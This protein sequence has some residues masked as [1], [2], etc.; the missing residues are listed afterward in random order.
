MEDSKKVGEWTYKLDRIMM[1]FKKVGPT[2]TRTYKVKSAGTGHRGT[3]LCMAKNDKETAKDKVKITIS[4][5]RGYSKSMSL[6]KSKF[7]TPFPMSYLVII[8]L[9]PRF[10]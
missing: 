8:C 4:K 10:F 2:Y 1:N 7:L 9:E 3:Y 6:K 5:F